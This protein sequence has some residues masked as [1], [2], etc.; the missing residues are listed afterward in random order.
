M[1]N[2]RALQKGFVSNNILYV[3]GGDNSNLFEKANIDNW[4][5]KKKYFLLNLI[6]KNKIFQKIFF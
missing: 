4:E 1:T 3:F 2:C 6:L 5:C